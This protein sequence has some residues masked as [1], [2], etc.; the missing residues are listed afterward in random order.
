MLARAVPEL[1][2]QPR[3]RDRSRVPIDERR[4][5]QPRS[6]RNCE[7]ICPI[8]ARE[9]RNLSRLTYTSTRAPPNLPPSPPSL[10]ELHEIA[11]DAH[12]GENARS[13]LAKLAYRFI[14]YD[15]TLRSSSSACPCSFLFV[16]AR[17]E[18]AVRT[19][20]VLD[21]RDISPPLLLLPRFFFFSLLANINLSSPLARSRDGFF[22]CADYARA[23]ARSWVVIEQEFRR[24]SLCLTRGK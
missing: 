17:R 13:V 5:N 14:N 4:E 3:P 24:A 23:R 6:Y 15:A 7:T 19:R 9:H 20:F 22:R 10:L 11:P 12:S 1:I 8:S 18:S 2:I 16:R 21:S